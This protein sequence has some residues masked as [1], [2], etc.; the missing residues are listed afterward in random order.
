M[1]ELI[2]DAEIRID[3]NTTAAA[4]SI[5][6]FR[7]RLSNT[8][9]ALTS[10]TTRAAAAASALDSLKDS[11]QDAS[12]ALRTLRGRVQ[13]AADAL[14]ELRDNAR[15]ASTSLRTMTTRA[16]GANQRLGDLGDRTR[17]LRSDLDGLNGTLTTTG[18]GL[19]GLRGRLGTLSTSTDS[20]RLS[21]SNLAT[22][23]VALGSAAIPI[24]A[25]T[26]PIAAS[27]AA[28]GAAVAAFG[29]AIGGQVVAMVEASE[30]Q[31]K[32]DDAVSK[33]GRF[34]KEAAEAERAYLQAVEEMPPATR[35][36]AAA[37]ATFKD[38]YK[39]WSAALADDTMPVF[40]RSLAIA[41]AVLPKT[42]GLVRG[43]SAE[44]QHMMAV[45]AG[46][47][48][49][50][51]FD[52]LMSQFEEFATGSLS[53][54]TTG[55][56]RFARAIDTGEIGSEYREF[57]Q[58]VRENGPLV[59]DTLLEL[60]R[61]AVNI[62]VGFSDLGASVLTV[63]NAL[64]SLVNAIPTGLLSTFIQ[65]Y[66]ALKLLRLGMA[67]IAAVATSGAAAAVATFFRAVAFGGLGS[68]LG[69][70][71]TRMTAVHRA[72]LRLGI[73]AV[74]A[75]GVKEL[76][77]HA[78][79]AP[80]DVDRLTTSLKR[81]ADT[82]EATGELR[83]TFGS[84]DGLVQKIKTLQVE[85]QKLKDAQGAG[86][87]TRI[88]VL[89]DIAEAVSGAVQDMVKGSDSLNALKE[90]F[91]AVD[92]ALAGM[93]SGGHSQA[94]A[95]AFNQ[96]R[97]AAREQG[98]PL[99]ELN[100]LF[101]SYR[102][103]V[104]AVKAEQ[105]LA[106]AGMGLFGQQA[107]A[108]SEK[109]KDQKASADG[110]RQA[111]IA[112]NDVQ[113]AGLGGMIGFE[114]AI[115]AAT[116]AAKENA[117]SLDMVDGRLNLNSEKARN[118]ATALQDLAAKTDEA[119]SSARE[120]GA[121][122]SEV[123]RIYDRGR[124]QFIDAAVT[125][126]L[127]RKEAQAL[128]NQLL[129]TPDKTLRVKGDI[130][131]LKA[132]VEQVKKDIKTVPDT[133]RAELKGKIADLQGKIEVAK[134][135]LRSVPPSMQSD[136]RARIADL[137]AKVAA[138]KRELKSVPPSKRSDLKATIA[139]LEKKISSAK[140]QIASVPPS[141][142]SALKGELSQLRSAVAEAKRQLESIPDESVTIR[143]NYVQI[144]TVIPRGPNGQPLMRSKG[145]PVP[146]YAAG[147][148]VQSYPDGGLVRGPGTA[149]SDSILALSSAGQ[150]FRVSNT[151]FVVRAAAV[152]RYG[153]PL[154]EA[155]NAMRLPVPAFASGGAPGG[156][157]GAGMADT[158]RDLVRGLVDGMAAMYGPVMAEARRMAAA[159]VTAAEDELQISSPSRR[160]RTIGKQVGTGF[161]KGLTGE[162]S[163]ID[164]TVKAMAAAITNAFKGSRSRTDDRLV[165]MLTRGNA[166][167]QKLAA[168]RDALAKRIADA[169]KYASDTATAAR[170]TGSLGQL[171]KDDYFAPR[172]I[173]QGMDRAAK[174]I[175]AFT[176]TL[177][178]L[179]KRGLSRGLI[180]QLM[181]M[182][183][184]AGLNYA[185]ALA[186]QDNAAIRRLNKLELSVA[187]ASKRLGT[188]GADTLYD[189]GR[190]A[191]RGFLS[192]LKGQQK[193]IERT[194]L[195]I[196]KAMQKSIRRALDIRS[197]SRVMELIGQLTTLG[198]ARGLVR[199]IPA[200][201]RSM[202][203]VSGAVAVPPVR[204]AA[205]PNLA[206]HVAASAARGQAVGRAVTYQVAIVNRGVIASPREAEDWLAAAMVRLAR[207]RRLPAAV[208][209]G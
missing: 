33:H 208:G 102:D 158:G 55:M 7:T 72:A 187:D 5:R 109:L 191:S 14:G 150:P 10:L 71:A 2:G 18:A 48:Q 64:A 170:A 175:R 86:T 32:Y 45:I 120:S 79:G 101:P 58:Y 11:A 50:G 42:T 155:L 83:T 162:R 116:K 54:A 68:A 28:A 115:D 182:G 167:L 36:A 195:G 44:L 205:V 13:A 178:N 148:R 147:G 66:A 132:K 16:D 111:L 75:V 189:A 159:A 135:Q 92:Q 27:A 127:T 138:A 190:Q 129:K 176:S 12:R 73:L 96:I 22:A 47:T 3:M 142:R 40:T 31:K 121:S 29:V 144:R 69:G 91:A 4:Q 117:G 139:D 206:R 41:G 154:L 143:T 171:V 49:T 76:A 100:A 146:G 125:M 153:L 74:A 200:V 202:V 124:K 56:V 181:E 107:I 196:A 177:A 70:I 78:R 136:I 197:P 60:A 81:L 188:F 30:A 165:S 87:G 24:A 122:W 9:T 97:D 19:T 110:L 123:N 172:L 46:A 204:R 174:R 94:A 193:E 38:E 166:R 130:A 82:G 185:K 43:A 209:G 89:D 106:A 168:Q 152:R 128:A 98:I 80:P 126:G 207:A 21:T 37:L 194:M 57:M 84:V 192:G 23:L 6:T 179:R 180:R 119:A 133:K 90:D 34:S 186:G 141:K 173:E 53:R 131:D 183:P 39:A 112:L 161:L 118:A 25:A 145:G 140:K 8:N 108:T 99:K 95:A 63:V 203:Q 104:A 114:A 51:T 184:E 103:T 1:A 164:Q 160:F 15:T 163:K 199:P 62:V 201:E 65:M 169:Q 77:Q 105:Q 93:A 157:A 149:T 156:G 67:G 137:Q 113:R 52:R 198:L 26:V 17:T 151:E 35:R 59:S 88:P 85:T 20:T 134:K 61:V